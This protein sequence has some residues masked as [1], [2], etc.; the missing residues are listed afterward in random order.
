MIFQMVK[1]GQDRKSWK[2]NFLGCL[3]TY[4]FII[5]AIFSVVF[6]VWVDYWDE[7]N[8]D[9]DINDEKDNNKRVDHLSNSLMTFLHIVSVNTSEAI[10]G[11]D[12]IACL[13][14]WFRR[15]QLWVS[16]ENTESEAN[17]ERDREAVEIESAPELRILQN[18]EDVCSGT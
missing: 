11:F 3:E 5:C 16:D 8:C 10:F 14:P 15:L 9:D 7:M 17:E 18:H 12:I 6:V 1:M 13:L 4:F 2:S